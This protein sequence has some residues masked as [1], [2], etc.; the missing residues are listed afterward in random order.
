MRTIKFRAWDKEEKK[1]WTV[2]LIS[3]DEEL[4]RI[5]DSQYDC[6]PSN[7]FELMQF[8]WLLDKNWKEIYEGDIV[9]LQE[10]HDSWAVRFDWRNANC[11]EIFL[12]IKDIFTLR[13]LNIEWRTF[14]SFWYKDEEERFKLF[15]SGYYIETAEVIW[16]IYENPELLSNTK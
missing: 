16:N 11:S 12:E 10:W 3:F 14:N 9:S 4:I 13:G 8:T 7:Q 5:T 1:M 15:W 2:K 6:F